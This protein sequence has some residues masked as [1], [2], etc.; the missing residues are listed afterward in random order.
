M[1]MLLLYI[2]MHYEQPQEAQPIC[3]SSSFACRPVPCK[4]VTNGNAPDYSQET[5]LVLM[6]CTWMQWVGVVYDPLLLTW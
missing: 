3:P 6:V 5:I 1:C 4:A 2:T